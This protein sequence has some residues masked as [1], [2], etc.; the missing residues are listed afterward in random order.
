MTIDNAGDDEIE[1]CLYPYRYI[2]MLYVAKCRTHSVHPHKCPYAEGG[3]EQ[4]RDALPKTG[5]TLL[6]PADASEKQQRNGDKDHEQH[7][8]FTIADDT[9]YNHAKE[10]ASQN[11]RKHHE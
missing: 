6:R 10:D 11:V 5:D 9:G 7:D 2:L 3:W 4:P 1:D 8:V